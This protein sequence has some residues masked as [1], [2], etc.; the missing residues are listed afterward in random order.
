M[1]RG[2]P[3]IRPGRD[4]RPV[5]SAWPQKGLPVEADVT[6]AD[7]LVGRNVFDGTFLL[8]T[9]VLLESALDHD[10]ELM[11]RYFDAAGVSYAP[12]GKT[13]MAPRIWERQLAAGAW[14]ITVATAWQAS[15]AATAG[16][17]RI[18]IANEVVDAG[19]LA[20]LRTSLERD[21]PEAITQV[22]SVEVV[23]LL[24]SV[25]EGSPRR[26]PLLIDVGQVG[27]RTGVRSVEA[28]VKV[29]R[30]VVD[31]TPLRLAGV[32]CFEGA[33]PG[34]TPSD[35]QD[36]MEAL[37]TMVRVVAERIAELVAAD[38]STELMVSGGGSKAFDLVIARL[39][40]PL[41]T[42][43]PVRLVVRSGAVVTHDHRLYAS[44]SPLRA[45]TDEWPALR[46]AL[47][48]WAPVLSRPEDD[49]AIIGAGRRDLPF[50]AGMPSVVKVRRGSGVVE[51]AVG[52]EVTG[53]NDQHAFARLSR[54]ANLSVGDLV[55]LGISHPCSVFDRWRWI[56]VVDDGYDVVDLYETVF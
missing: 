16:A 49:L 32:T 35:Q 18:L 28:A 15:V 20:W 48:V 1:R 11:A 2:V 19:S 40:A 44:S 39:G 52:I 17:P 25:L 3:L 36:S 46:P 21:A 41:A 24:A 12:H 50:D 29:A 6:F 10:I 4:E 7:A 22:D 26:L 30:A 43:L 31:A 51:A 33:A 13:T 45:A 37:L 47:E 54:G 55:G 53:L 56:P 14:A 27:A 5:A 42:P 23:A 8:P 9:M 34:A 38:G